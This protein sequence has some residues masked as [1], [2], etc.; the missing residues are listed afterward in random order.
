VAQQLDWLRDDSS[1]AAFAASRGNGAFA[2]AAG[3]RFRPG[4]G[5]QPVITVLPEG[6]MMFASAV[7]SADRRYVRISPFPQFSTIRS[8]T[9]FSIQGGQTNTA[10]NVGGAGGGGLG[11]GGFGGGGFGGGGG[12]FGGGGGGFF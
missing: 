9:T 12:G 5:Y 10:P 4:V 3:N 2:V 7:I 6:A 8:V 1:L 11:G